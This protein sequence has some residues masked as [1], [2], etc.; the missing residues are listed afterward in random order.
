MPINYNHLRALTARKL[1]SALIK[2]E[3]CLRNQR[4]SH[5]RY[6]HADGRRVTVSFHK[7]SNT[8]PLKT[9]KSIIED[10]ACWTQEDIER[11]GLSK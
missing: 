8:F 2:D 10:Q 1:I 7:T 4:G 11:L 6:R 3:F 5:Q 9:L